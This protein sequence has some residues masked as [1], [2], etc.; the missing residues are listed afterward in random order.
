M[1]K[2]NYYFKAKEVNIIF[3]QTVLKKKNTNVIL[4]LS[5]II[6]F[7]Q[8]FEMKLMR[9]KETFLKLIVFLVE[10]H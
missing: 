1:I 6:F 7:K 3:K 10:L 9:I 5:I 4:A 8:Y 2:Y